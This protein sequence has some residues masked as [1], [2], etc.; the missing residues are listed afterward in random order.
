VG[1]VSNGEFT[2]VRLRDVLNRAGVR[3]SAV[4][5]GHYGAD[6]HLTME[7][8]RPAISRGVPIEKAMDENTLLIW[9]MNGADLPLAHG[10]PLRILVPG[11]VGSTSQKWLTRIW[12]RDQEHDGPGMTGLSYR[13]PRYPV[14]PG[15]EVPHEDMEVMETLLIKSIITRPATNSE[16][17]AGEPLRV[18]GHAWSGETDVENVEVSMDY[19]VSWQDTEFTPSPNKYA[20]ATFEADIDFPQAG[21]LRDLGPRDRQRGCDAAHGRAGLEPARLRQQQHASHCRH[22]RL[23]GRTLAV[24]VLFGLLVVAGRGLAPRPVRPTIRA[25][26]GRGCRRA[27]AARRSTSTASP[28]TRWPSSSSSG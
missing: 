28:A 13:M 12:I 14:A 1:A 11:W 8:G 26:S 17:P 4:Y 16:V 18:R 27:R 3:P 21:L 24:V 5:T 25:T 7:E 9:G 15:T 2:G 19:G 6:P 23:M 20:W 22:G 10:Y